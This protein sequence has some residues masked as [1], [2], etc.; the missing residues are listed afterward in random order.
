VDFDTNGKVFAVLTDFGIA[1]II[2]P[3]IMLVKKF[4]TVNVEGA[5]TV[6]AAPEV[7][8]RFRN[9][10]QEEVRA[11]EAKSGDIY[12]LSMIIYGMLTSSIPWI[13]RRSFRST[14]HHRHR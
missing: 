5:S 6:Y 12:S 3:T 7:L 14:R 4:I 10:I 2:D 13:H 8:Y 9:H 11:K 1:K